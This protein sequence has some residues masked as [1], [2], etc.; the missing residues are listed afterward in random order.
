MSIPA[1]AHAQL[2]LA[3]TH[4]LSVEELCYLQHMVG[5]DLCYVH[6]IQLNFALENYF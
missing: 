2:S 5:Q 3:G 4:P 6:K 1:L